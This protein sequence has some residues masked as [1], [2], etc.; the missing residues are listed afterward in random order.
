MWL[1]RL[2]LLGLLLFLPPAAATTSYAQTVR[3]SDA[4]AARIG[5]RIWQNECAGTVSGLT[6]WNAGEAFASLGINHYIW[7]PRGKTGPFEESFPG[8]LAFLSAR[9][10]ALPGWLRDVRG[11]DC[12]WPTR[13][14][15]E[16]DQGG[17]RLAGLRALL[18][19]PE[20]VALQ[21][22]FSADRLA[23]AVPKMTDALPDAGART[24]VR[25]R[26]ARVA[27]TPGGAYALIDYVNFKGEGTS[28]TERYAGRGWGLLQVLEGMRD[29]DGGGGGSPTREF[30]A[31]AARVLTERVQNAPPERR[32]S[33]WLPGWLSRVRGYATG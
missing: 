21:A 30:A 26:F 12:P 28:P 14:A 15:F 6:S 1:T 18:S 17:E 5:R 10:I 24:R 31:S 13:E 29:D 4:E 33:R 2:V 9:G 3:V 16:A 32:E 22:R 20:V 27:A 23:A 25:E 7:Y 19:R 8:L 11:N